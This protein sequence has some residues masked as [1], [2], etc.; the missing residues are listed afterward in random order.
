MSN[1]SVYQKV[2][3][4]N[5]AYKDIFNTETGKTVLKDIAHF[6]G[7]NKVSFVPGDPHLTSYKE[8]MRAVYLH[9]A[10]ILNQTEQ[11]IFKYKVEG[12]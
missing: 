12:E 8:G 11:D 6:S 7:A 2:K 3:D 1:M 5:K 4:R 10:K 9:I